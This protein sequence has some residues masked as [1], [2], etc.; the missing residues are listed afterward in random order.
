MLRILIADDH[1]IVAGDGGGESVMLGED[2]RQLGQALLGSVLFI[3]ADQDDEAV[4]LR[5]LPGRAEAVA[6]QRPGALALRAGVDIWR[7]TYLGSLAAACQVSRVGN[8]PLTA[9]ELQREIANAA[10]LVRESSF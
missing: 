2:L 6:V 9:A 7:A 5:A 1:E 10:N 8:T 3:A 4:R